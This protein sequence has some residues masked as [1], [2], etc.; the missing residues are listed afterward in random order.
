MKKEKRKTDCTKMNNIPSLEL[1][2]L[3]CHSLCEVTCVSVQLCLE[4]AVSLESITSGSWNLS[5]FSS[6]QI[7]E[8]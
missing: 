8:S 6:S 5:T 7:P 2:I 1:T 4:D 3:C